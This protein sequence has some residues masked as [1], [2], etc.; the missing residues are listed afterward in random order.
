M[1]CGCKLKA[2]TDSSLTLYDKDLG[3]W[4]LGLRRLECV[5]CKG[6][7]IFNP[8]LKETASIVSEYDLVVKW[9]EEEWDISKK[10][11]VV[12]GS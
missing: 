9:I 11:E 6:G 1:I 4:F 3:Q 8:K 2:F 12:V 7:F 5:E 10:H